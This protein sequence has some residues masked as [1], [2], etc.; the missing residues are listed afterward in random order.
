VALMAYLRD[1]FLSW[2]RAWLPRNSDN[3]KINQL[4]V[5]SITHFALKD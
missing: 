3:L 5:A 1:D 2:M 4:K